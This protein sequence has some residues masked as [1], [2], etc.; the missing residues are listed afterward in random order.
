MGGI[1]Q[2][3]GSGGVG[4]AGQAVDGLQKAADVGGAGDGDEGDP[5]GVF[6]QEL[7]EVV[8]VETAVGQRP[9]VA[10]V[11]VLP[12]GQIVGVVL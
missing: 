4:F 10:H 6:A 8:F 7:V 11:G 12:P 2:N 5:P 3:H 1:D 9:H